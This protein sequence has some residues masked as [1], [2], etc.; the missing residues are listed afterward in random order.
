MRRGCRIARF[1]GAVLGVATDAAL[2]SQALAQGCAMCKSSL[3]G[4]N[5]PTAQAFN[6]TTLFLMAMPYVVVGSVGAWM[7]VSTR[8]HHGSVPQPPESDGTEREAPP[9]AHARVVKGGGRESSR[10]DR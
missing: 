3:D 10:N 8:R 2:S 9:D 4:P 5:D 6:V 1:A 7:Y